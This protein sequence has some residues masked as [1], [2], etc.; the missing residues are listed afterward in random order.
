MEGR[1]WTL[2]T[3]VGDECLMDTLWTGFATISF[4]RRALLHEVSYNSGI[5][6]LR[7]IHSSQNL[8]KLNL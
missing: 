7:L 5:R 3:G 1:R 8:R 6:F 4:V 2:L